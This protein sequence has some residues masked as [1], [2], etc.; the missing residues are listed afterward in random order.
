MS[1]LIKEM[2]EQFNF[3]VES[4]YIYLAMS[5]YFKEIEMEGFAQYMFVQAH[6][7]FE[8]ARDFYNFLF[9][10]EERPEYEEI[11]KPRNEYDGLEEAF[12][13]ALEHEMEVTRRIEALYGLAI[14]EKNYKVVQFLG[15]YVTEQVEEL[16]K[17]RTIARRLERIDANWVGLYA[18]DKEL[19]TM[20]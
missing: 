18:L 17:F 20:K 2:K 3:E 12:S 9:D 11:R 7:E 19:A 8:H 10:I 6:E 13:E 4:G 14:E 1:K 15:K 16:N 5:A